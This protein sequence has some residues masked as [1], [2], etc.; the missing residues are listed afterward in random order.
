[1]SHPWPV[2]A[3]EANYTSI[4]SGAGPAPMLAYGDALLAHGTSMMAVAGASAGNAAGTFASW[5]G[6][7]A[8]SAELAGA[9]LNA[10][11]FGL[12]AISTAAGS[13]NNHHVASTDARM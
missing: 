8:V 5:Q 1:M 9:S 13:D 3:P 12:R 4:T 11:M 7:G 10:Q 6:A 2:F